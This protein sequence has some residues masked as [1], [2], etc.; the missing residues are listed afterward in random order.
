[1]SFISKLQTAFDKNRN[2]EN[3]VAMAKY[4][5]NLFSF[6]GIKAEQRRTIFKEV[7]NTNKKELFVLENTSENPYLKE[8]KDKFEELDKNITSKSIETSQS[9]SSF[10]K[11]Q[12][13]EINT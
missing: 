5:K 1:M 4:M 3:A 7:C 11:W 6:Y 2:P 9:D 10:K 13:I 8:N 12:K